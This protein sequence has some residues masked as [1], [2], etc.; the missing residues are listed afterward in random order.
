M[1]TQRIVGVSG[2]FPHRVVVSTEIFAERLLLS[3]IIT[4]SMLTEVEEIAYEAAH[5]VGVIATKH[6][7]RRRLDRAD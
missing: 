7:A 5:E 3:G 4:S 2:D 6:E 1:S